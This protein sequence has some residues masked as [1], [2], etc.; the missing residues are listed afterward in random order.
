MSHAGELIEDRDDEEKV[1]EKRRLG[2][3]LIL[4]WHSGESRDAE[5]SLSLEARRYPEVENRDWGYGRMRDG[6]G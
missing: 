2:H 6:S 1:S 5:D 3:T 4:V